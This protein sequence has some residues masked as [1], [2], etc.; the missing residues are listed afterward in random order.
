MDKTTLRRA[1]LVVSILLLIFGIFVIAEATTMPMTASY[2]GVES[3]WYVAPALIPLF[4]GGGLILLSAVLLFVAIKDGALKGFVP[5]LKETYPQ[6]TSEK[7]VR[8][9]L[10]VLSLASFI[11]LYVPRVDFMIAIAQ[12]LFYLCG[13]FYAENDQ[14]MKKMTYY[15]LGLNGL[16]TIIL[17]TGL[18]PVLVGLYLYT[19]DII[20]LLG[21]IGMMIYSTRLART[22]GV[23]PGRMKTVI[24]VSVLTPLILCPLFRYALRTPLPHEGLLMNQFNAVYYGIKYRNR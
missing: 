20:A 15:Y 2:G 5:F 16:L 13:A 9:V 6:L 23:E 11:Y 8:T 12:F 4:I 22:H 1:D 7:T 14:V 3:H 24:W 18:W 21:L 10:V 17:I 19:V